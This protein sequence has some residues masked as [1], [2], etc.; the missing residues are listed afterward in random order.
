M[1]PGEFEGKAFDG[2]M[3]NILG[4]HVALVEEGRA[5]PDVF[6]GDS[7]LPTKFTPDNRKFNMKP[8]RR[9]SLLPIAVQGALQS[10]LGPRLAA[11]ANLN[12][13]PLVKGVT[14]KGWQA[15]KA[16]LK[17]ALDKAC[18]GKLAKDAD[19]E[20]VQEMLDQLD[21]VVAQVANGE[22]TPDPA[23]ATDPGVDP[24]D[25]DVADDEGDDDG[26]MVKRVM[27][28]CQAKG[29]SPEDLE[30]LQAAMKPQVTAP[31]TE[32]ED[33]ALQPG[34][35]GPPAAAK[36]E[37]MVSKPAMDKAIKLAAD[38]AAKDAETSTI[39]RLNAIREAEKAVRPYIGELAL[40]QDSA[41]AV[42]RLALD[43]MEVD[44]EGVHPSAYPAM[45]KM[46]PV[47]GSTPKATQTKRVAM[48]A[49]QNDEFTKRFGPLNHLKHIRQ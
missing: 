10:Y 19:L 46:V 12:L 25:N 41:A 7:A 31:P 43:A 13:K 35:K 47:P 22:E 4:N 38:K 3:R 18:E 23:A 45:L 20:D 8:R 24:A 28:F 9:P 27:E 39:A 49:A 2:V 40:A 29:M 14:A 26:D 32:D 34:G 48:D 37:E 33:P 6:V 42:Y 17:V 21:T 11:D 15:D 36:K 30:A 16:R 5:G 1:T 44:I